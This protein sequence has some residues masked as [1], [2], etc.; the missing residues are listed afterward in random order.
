[1][2]GTEDTKMT[3]PVMLS[4]CLQSN[5]QSREHGPTSYSGETT[6]FSLSSHDSAAKYVVSPPF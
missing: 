1:M 3:K 2:P 4:R 5:N 6:W